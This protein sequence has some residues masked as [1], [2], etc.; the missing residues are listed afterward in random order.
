MNIELKN[1]IDQAYQIFADYKVGQTLDV[2]TQCCVTKSEQFELVNTGVSEIPFEL[3]YIYHTAG[4]PKDPNIKE[5]KHF[6]P[7]YLELTANLKFV[8]HSSEIV[9]K[10]FGEIKEWTKEEINILDKFGREFFKKCLTEYPLPENEIISSIL[11]MLDKGNFGIA[12]KLSDWEKLE[13]LESTL[14]FSDLIN[15]GFY[16]KKPNKLSSGFADDNTSQIVLN[17]L[18]SSNTKKTFKE[19]IERIIM[20]PTGISDKS[21]MELSWAYERLRG[22]STP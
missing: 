7:R 4:K 12:E 2:C 22:K 9:L 17:W 6:A 16:E 1:I 14:H 13:N 20:N 18:N 5:F 3:L 8:S 10:T 21:Q 19:R 15:H 11:I